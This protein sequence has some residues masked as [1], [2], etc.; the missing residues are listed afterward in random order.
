MKS[1]IR[2]AAPLLL[3]TLSAGPACAGIETRGQYYVYVASWIGVT[4]WFFLGMSAV[5]FFAVCAA[6]KAYRS[7]LNRWLEAS[8]RRK[9]T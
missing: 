6:Y 9:R 3:I 4:L 1:A 5:L 7:W 8:P 2:F